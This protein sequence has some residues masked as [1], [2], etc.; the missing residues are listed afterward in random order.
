MRSTALAMGLLAS[1]ILASA[2]SAQSMNNAT[3]P[4]AAPRAVVA[5]KVFSDQWR[6]SKLMGLDIY[7]EQ[8]EKLG[9]IDEIIVDKTGKVDSVIIGVGG[10]LGVGTRE[11]KVTMDKLQ[12]V[13]EP[14]AKSTASSAG[15][16]TMASNAPA[17][18]PAT[19][20]TTSASSTPSKQWYPDH[21]VLSGASKDQ[22][23]AM[24][25]FKYD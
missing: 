14:V 15:T 22:L 18:A 5:N 17:T 19:S 7:N 1:T 9:D 12:F 24:P 6:A 8:N 10:F 16:T 4:G 3:P 2:V 23:K 20:S 11:I 13:N 21:A 25:E